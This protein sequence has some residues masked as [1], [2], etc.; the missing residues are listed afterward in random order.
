MLL[1]C[2]FKE[3]QT[4]Y[5]FVSIIAFKNKYLDDGLNMQ[6]AAILSDYDGTLCPTGS[7]RCQDKSV[8]PKN[9]EDILWD[10]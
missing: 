4:A 1:L 2:I 10:I 6:I 7:I 5:E 3:I 8:I 9:L